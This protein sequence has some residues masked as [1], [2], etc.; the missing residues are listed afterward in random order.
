MR[1]E[2]DHCLQDVAGLSEELE[3]M[4][5]CKYIRHKTLLLNVILREGLAAMQ[6]HV[7]SEPQGECA[8]SLLL[9][10]PLLLAH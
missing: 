8:L 3:W 5:V 10:L 6:W 1:L 2:C 4:M 7:L 9:P